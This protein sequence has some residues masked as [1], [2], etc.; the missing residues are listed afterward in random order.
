AGTASPR[1]ADY[2]S[3][4]RYSK[5]EE[6]PPGVPWLDA[7]IDGTS[8]MGGLPRTSTRYGLQELFMDRPVSRWRMSVA[9][10]MDWT[11]RHCRYFHRLLSRHALLYTEMMTT[12]ALIHGDVPRHLDFNTEEHP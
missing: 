1:P 2:F 4:S 9:P 8:S 7:T 6:R 3:F 10:M 5:C 12:G 11:D